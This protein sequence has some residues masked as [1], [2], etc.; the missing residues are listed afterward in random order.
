MAMIHTCAKTKVK[1]TAVKRLVK[2]NGWLDM[3]GFITF[4]VNAQSVARILGRVGS[5]QRRLR[6]LTSF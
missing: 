1:C 4:H 6:S 5:E 3:A 2:T